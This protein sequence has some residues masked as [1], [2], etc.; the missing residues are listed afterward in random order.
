MSK[1]ALLWPLCRNPA[2]NPPLYTQEP[3]GLRVKLGIQMNLTD[4]DKNPIF[5]FDTLMLDS[6][7]EFNSRN[8]SSFC[9]YVFEYL[10]TYIELWSLN[11]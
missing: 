4:W 2:L 7:S 3:L 9:K 10:Q 5:T 11:D 1:P 8:K 6:L